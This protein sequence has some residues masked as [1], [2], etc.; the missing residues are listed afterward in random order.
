MNHIIAKPTAEDLATAMKFDK[1]I[2]F[3][4]RR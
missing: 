1:V 3:N 2:L 4:S